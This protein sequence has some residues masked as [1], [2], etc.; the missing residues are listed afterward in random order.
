MSNFN[1]YDEYEFLDGCH[2]ARILIN[3]LGNVTDFVNL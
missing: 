1:Q 2:Q 3:F